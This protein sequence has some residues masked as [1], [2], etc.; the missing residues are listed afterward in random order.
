MPSH[1]NNQNI[2]NSL[3]YYTNVC[4]TTP[5]PHTPSPQRHMKCKE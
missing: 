2:K 4:R 3:K 1:K 5:T